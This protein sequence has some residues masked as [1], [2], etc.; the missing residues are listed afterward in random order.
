MNKGIEDGNHFAEHFEKQKKQKNDFNSLLK[1]KLPVFRDANANVISCVSDQILLTL[2]NSGL[3]IC[4]RAVVN[5]LKFS[6]YS[7]RNC[8]QLAFLD[9]LHVYFSGPT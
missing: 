4:S 3:G 2:C 9:F 5:R 8:H 6:L 7:I 1:K